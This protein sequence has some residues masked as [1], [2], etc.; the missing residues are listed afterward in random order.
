MID[1]K[2]PEPD[3]EIMQAVDGESICVV[4]TA[5]G[6]AGMLAEALDLHRDG[7]HVAVHLH[8]DQQGSP[9]RYTII[10]EKFW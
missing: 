10:A 8:R 3:R 4:I 9:R 5:P 1:A 2:Q 6:V 7:Y